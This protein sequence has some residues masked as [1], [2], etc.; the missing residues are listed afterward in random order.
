MLIFI[1][2]IGSDFNLYEFL[3]SKIE[4]LEFVFS[5]EIMQLDNFT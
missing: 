2:N 1:T 3:S 4:A 5:I